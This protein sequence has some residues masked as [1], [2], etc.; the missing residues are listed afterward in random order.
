MPAVA[1]APGL[2]YL[3]VP[4]FIAKY[5]NLK[6]SSIYD[7]RGKSI[8]GPHYRKFARAPH[9]SHDGPDTNALSFSVY[10]LKNDLINLFETFLWHC[11]ALTLQLKHGHY[12]IAC[13]L[14]MAKY[15]NL[16]NA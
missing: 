8:I 2:G 1:E 14:K 6:K 11:S 12:I 4:G 3:K 16:F 10:S 9:K 15:V 5:F 7:C 13:C